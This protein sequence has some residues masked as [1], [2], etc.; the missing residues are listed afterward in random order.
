MALTALPA[1]YT[2]D[3]QDFL[4]IQVFPPHMLVLSHLQGFFFFN[5]IYQQ[6]K[7][8]LWQLQS[9]LSQK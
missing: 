2:G 5:P 4:K 9:A 8:G 3:S 1:M 6:L 7:E